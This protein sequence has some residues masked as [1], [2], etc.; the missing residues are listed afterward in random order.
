MSGFFSSEIY[1]AF[2][3]DADVR[4]LFTAEAEI[5]A[6]LEFEGALARAEAV[7]GV[8]PE[9]AAKRISDVCRT[10]TIDPGDIAAGVARD[11]IPIPALVSALRDAVGG[12]AASFV[13]WGVTTH[14]VIDTGLVLRLRA[15]LDIVDR[16]LQ[17]IAD[18]LAGLSQ[19]HETTVMA[20]RTWGQ[21][22]TPVT[23]GLKAAG[24][25]APLVRHQ[26]RLN[27]L[28]T[29]VLVVSFGGASGTLSVIGEQAEA[30]EAVL[31]AELDLA[32]P[33]LPW[34]A[35]RDA[36]GEF[37]GV[38]A[39][40]AGSLAKMAR[41][42]SVLSQTEIGELRESGGSSSTMPQKANPVRAQAIQAL[43][44]SVNGAASVLLAGQAQESERDPSGWMAEWI[45]IPDLANALGGALKLADE[46]V[47]D[48]SV[49]PD[50][51]AANLDNGTG[52]ILAEAA[53]FAL[54]RHM[55][56]TEAIGLVKEACRDAA[57]SG[58]HLIDILQRRTDAPVDWTVLRDPRRQTGIAARL[59]RRSLR[60]D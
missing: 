48:L 33:P 3:G 11:G 60:P 16:R 38:A 14:D 13:H 53:S 59:A 35:Q 26:A 51:M 1:G 17:S 9:D 24:W 21:H 19:Q 18:T 39:L 10:T 45:A 44:R 4:G 54:S 32:R 34:H 46:L 5:R 57:A 49:D 56:R 20:G 40:I 55:P 7:C 25:R 42:V 37:A 41:D 27:D 8:I 58:R 12:E 50:R 47:R 30:V 15:L 43:A 2:Y 36:I 29:R 6:W 22:S 23:F 31:T 28:R 52:L